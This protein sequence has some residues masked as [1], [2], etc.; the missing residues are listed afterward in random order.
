MNYDNDGKI[1]L[2]EETIRYLERN[3][4]YLKPS[5]PS[6]LYNCFL[7]MKKNLQI[8]KDDQ[9]DRFNKIMLYINVK[10]SE[11]NINC[12]IKIIVQFYKLHGYIPSKFEVNL[13]KKSDPKVFIRNI[14]DGYTELNPI[15][16]K[17]LDDNIPGWDDFNLIYQD[18][19]VMRIMKIY[20]EDH[21]IYG[22]ENQILFM[23][24]WINMKKYLK[25]YYEKDLLN[26]KNKKIISTFIPNLNNA[27]FYS[28]DLQCDKFI[29]YYNKNNKIINSA[30]CVQIG[31]VYIYVS[32]LIENFRNCYYNKINEKLKANIENWHNNI[33]CLSRVEKFKLFLDFKK[34]LPIIGERFKIGNSVFSV[35]NFYHYYIIGK[36][37]LT[38]KDNIKMDR[39]LTNFYKYCD[40]KNNYNNVESDETDQR[41]DSDDRD[42]S[43]ERDQKVNEEI[44]NKNSEE[45]KTTYSSESGETNS[46]NDISDQH[47]YFYSQSS[48]DQSHQTIY[49]FTE[50][51]DE[52][53]YDQENQSIIFDNDYIF[54]NNYLAI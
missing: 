17:T 24:K 21:I 53:F 37:K 49:P 43:D 22:E 29:E 19:I 54:G 50:F 27:I 32:K 13:P 52:L 34:R 48:F 18:E 40:E 4:I 42:D 33:G 7:R 15:Q 16:R 20:K 45:E 47:P 35:G 14:V 46:T 12:S 38:K 26:E 25:K 28:I 9:R 10:N 30:D 3:V 11:N 41:D 2:V 8:M 31:S 39:I 36:K 44:D 5:D 23:K 1:C 51:N 6:P